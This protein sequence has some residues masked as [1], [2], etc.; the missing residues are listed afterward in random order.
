MAP[1]I[2]GGD[3]NTKLETGTTTPDTARDLEAEK[4]ELTGKT[5]EALK[6]MKAE[7]IQKMSLEDLEAA[8]QKSPGFKKKN[9]TKEKGESS[10]FD[11]RGNN[12]IELH[13]GLADIEP[14]TVRGVKVNIHPKNLKNPYNNNIASDPEAKRVYD[15]WVDDGSPA[16]PKEYFVRTSAYREGMKGIFGDDHGKI[17]IFTGDNYVVT[18]KVDQ[19]ELAQVKEQVTKEAKARYA[20][21]GRRLGWAPMPLTY[22]EYQEPT[23]TVAPVEKKENATLDGIDLAALQEEMGKGAEITTLDQLNAQRP[24]FSKLLDKVCESIGA[25]KDFKAHICATAFRESRF[26]DTAS[27]DTQ[28]GEGSNSKTMFQFFRSAKDAA[29]GSAEG[30][31]WEHATSQP[32]FQEMAQ[33]WLGKTEFARAES[34]VA[35]VL[36]MTSRC[37]TVAKK[38][39][40]DLT[41]PL[42]T[43]DFAI[44]RSYHAGS[45]NAAKVGPEISAYFSGK[46]EKMDCSGLAQRCIDFGALANR[47]RTFEASS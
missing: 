44:L 15:Q 20:D 47:Y 12:K 4:K 25:T 3:R 35:D 27:G 5:G 10:E 31:G 29:S 18:K 30:S 34:V 9:L 41:K 24:N 23:G 17:R 33:K 38:A 39:G 8:E 42:T 2:E 13:I 21:Q 40:I 7:F 11:S 45:G 36:A 28:F 26:N 32:Y 16:E 1:P 46:K 43:K 37:L 14:E 19:S 6:D 22:S